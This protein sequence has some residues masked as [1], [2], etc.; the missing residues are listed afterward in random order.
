MAQ[1]VLRLRFSEPAEV[2]LSALQASAPR[3]VALAAQEKNRRD[4]RIALRR[5]LDVQ[6]GAAG[7]A[8]IVQLGPMGA[9]ASLQPPADEPPPRVAPP[10][11]A[12]AQ[13]S[14]GLR[15]DFTRLVFRW[16]GVTTIQPVQTRDR[17]ELRFNRASGSRCSSRRSLR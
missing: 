10:S 14:V 4:V 3:T 5:R 16:P 15:D 7:G 8:R 17:L 11:E 2:D 6:V 1:G 12:E 13:V 9:P